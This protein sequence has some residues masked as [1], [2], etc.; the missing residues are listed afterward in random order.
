MGIPGFTSTKKGLMCLA[1][2]NNT[3]PLVGL[4]HFDIESSNLL[5][6]HCAPQN[7]SKKY[8]FFIKC[9]THLIIFGLFLLDRK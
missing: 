7:I 1:Q 5:L 9:I 2:V 6:S 3:V 8:V 4:K